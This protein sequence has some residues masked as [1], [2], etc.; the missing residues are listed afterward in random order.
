MS[1]PQT[2]NVRRYSGVG[3]GVIE[4]NIKLVGTIAINRHSHEVVIDSSSGYVRIR[5]YVHNLLPTG[6]IKL[7]GTRQQ[8][9]CPSLHEAVAGT[10]KSCP[11]SVGLNG[12]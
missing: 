1:Y 9:P 11:V 8:P 4:S 6:S 5:H 7:A 2:S 10:R 3:E 12:L